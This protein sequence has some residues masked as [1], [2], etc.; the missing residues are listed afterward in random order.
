MNGFRSD[1]DWSDGAPTPSDSLLV[2]PR[3]NR[4]YWIRGERV[5]SDVNRLEN[6]EDKFAGLINADDLFFRLPL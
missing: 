4:I 1:L 5:P 6:A 2:Q 3:D